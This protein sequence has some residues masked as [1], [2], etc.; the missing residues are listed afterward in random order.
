MTEAKADGKGRRRA[1]DF[2]GLRLDEA[3]TKEDGKPVYVCENVASTLA[4]V[5]KDVPCAGKYRFARVHDEGEYV[6]GVTRK[7]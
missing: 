3:L 7:Q 6:G 5:T 2:M 4:G 1:A